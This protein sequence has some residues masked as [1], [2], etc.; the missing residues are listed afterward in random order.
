[1]SSASGCR[2][3]V[4]GTSFIMSYK[5]DI[6]VGAIVELRH[7]KD[8]WRVV[9]H[10]DAEP[11]FVSQYN[12]ESLETGQKKRVFLHE[13]FEKNTT[14]YEELQAFFR[15]Q[16]KLPENEPMDQV[17]YLDRARKTALNPPVICKHRSIGTRE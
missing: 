17:R 4:I 15:Q 13:I 9:S 14:T 8:D 1:M 7:H 2:I 12:I 11:R 16:S 6:P 5:P 10:Y 3:A